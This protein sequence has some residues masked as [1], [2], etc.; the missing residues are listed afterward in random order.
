MLPE[1]TTEYILQSEENVLQYLWCIFIYSYFKRPYSLHSDYFMQRIGL[2][3][4]IKVETDV[5]IET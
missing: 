5:Y 4:L 2:F 3:I 1:G